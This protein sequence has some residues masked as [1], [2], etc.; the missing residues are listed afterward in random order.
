MT[1][2]SFSLVDEQSGTKTS[3]SYS[4]TDKEGERILSC[5]VD[6]YRC[7]GPEAAFASMAEQMMQSITSHVCAYER[8]KAAD[9]IVPKPD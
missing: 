6:C 5:Y 9:P 3:L 8:A 4:V 1:T 7:K 2:I